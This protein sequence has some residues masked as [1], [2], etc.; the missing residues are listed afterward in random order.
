MN[1][2]RETFDDGR[3]AD[4]GLADENGIVLRPARKNLDDAL[5]LLGAPDDRIELALPRLL[6]QV[7][8]V[9]VHGRRLLRLA[10]GSGLG[11]LGGLVAFFTFDFTFAL[12]SSRRACRNELLNREAH[13]EKE[14]CGGILTFTE[15]GENEMDRV[16]DLAGAGLDAGHVENLLRAGRQR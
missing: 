10:V 6:G 14:L 5:Q 16:D 9:S 8:S 3:L 1:C 12:G 11:G 4:A 7:P 2:L 15:H 13:V